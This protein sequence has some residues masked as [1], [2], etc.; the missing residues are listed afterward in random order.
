MKNI[1]EKKLNAL[2]KA[3]DILVE[4]SNKNDGCVSEPYAWEL[5]QNLNKLVKHL[6]KNKN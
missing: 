3:S 1:S 6:E 4:V 2:K 5:S